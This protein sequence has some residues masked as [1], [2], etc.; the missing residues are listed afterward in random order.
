MLNVTAVSPTAE[1]HLTIW[2]TGAAR[3]QASSL[4]LPAGDTRA[5]LVAAALGAD[6]TVSV[7]NNAGSTNVI[8]DVVGYHTV[9]GDDL[10]PTDPTRILDSRQP[11]ESPTPWSARESRTVPVRG[12]AGVPDDATGVFLNVTAVGPSAATHLTVWPTGSDRPQASSLNLGAGQTRP[13]LVFSGVGDDGS[14]SVFNNA[15]TTHVVIDVVGY[16]VPDDPP[17]GRASE[18]TFV[19]LAPTRVL[20]SRNG[21][22]FSTPWGPKAERTILVR[23][24][25]GIPADATSVVLNLTAVSPSAAT[26]LTVWPSGG[27]KPTASNLNVPAGLTAANLVLAQI[28]ADGRIRIRNNE[29]SVHVVADVVGYHR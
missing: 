19:G 10:V 5:N 15:G 14:V 6:G 7:F 18:S 11:V 22:G 2:P 20:D 25:N 26:H 23:A 1:T 12:V 28:G 27:E 13:N 21:I 17:E 29:G 24:T 3:P 8:V 4:N 16:T 9:D